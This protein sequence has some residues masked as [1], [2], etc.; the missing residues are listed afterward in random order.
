MPNWSEVL[1]EIQDFADQHRAD[2]KVARTALDV[3]RRKYLET[4][5]AHTNRNIIAYYSGFLSKPGI[6]GLE[7]NDED[8]NGFMM[9]VHRLDRSK[10][11]DLILHTPGGSIAA[12]QSIVNYLHKMFGKDIRAIVP[13]IA[14][15]AGTMVACSTKEIVMGTHS[16]IGPIDP[17]LRDIPA[18]G[19]ILE[20]K[21]A[22][23]EVRED[24]ARIPIWQTIISQYRPT[25]L[26]QCEDSIKWSNSFVREQLRNVM[27]YRNKDKADKAAKVVRK[28]TDYR[29]GRQSH[30][31]H[32]H[33]EDCRSIGLKVVPLENDDTLQDLVLTVHHCYM[34]AL[35]NTLSFKIIENHLGVAFIKQVR[36]FAIPMPQLLPTQPQ[37]VPPVQPTP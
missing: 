37:I 21:R 23:K 28:L 34:H 18:Y 16:N 14:M 7:I 2:P 13:Q 30:E 15:S 32:L 11:L 12:T 1:K 22:F 9:A 5:F 33:Y 26:S 25:F 4:L 35:M 29:L 20:F 27:F 3:V 31:R 36:E 24:P 17:H 10:G 19:V 8:K 6:V